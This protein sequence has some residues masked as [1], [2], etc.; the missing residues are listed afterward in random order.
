ML[1]APPLD[2]LFFW[3]YMQSV[4]IGL[5]GSRAALPGKR[6][7]RSS[8][9]EAQSFFAGDVAPGPRDPVT[10]IFPFRRHAAHGAA[11]KRSAP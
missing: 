8:G 1:A 9:S 3:N 11:G 4:R 6:Y 7:V 10:Y 2:S 5:G